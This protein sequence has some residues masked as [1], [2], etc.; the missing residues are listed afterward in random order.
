[1]PVQEMVEGRV[2]Q[3]HTTGTTHF[4]MPGA[5]TGAVATEGR[6]SGLVRASMTA[7][8]LL[9]RVITN[10]A[11]TDSTHTSRKALGAGA[12]SSTVTALTTGVF[13]DTVNTDSLTTGQEFNSQLVTGATGSVTTTQSGLTLS[14]TGANTNRILQSGD[15]AAG[16]M[17]LIAGSF[18]GLGG[19]DVLTTKAETEVYIT[20]RANTTMSNIRGFT[21]GGGT[22]A[23]TLKSRINLADGAQTITQASGTQGAFEDVTNTD[24]VVTGNEVAVTFLV[25]IEATRNFMSWQQIGTGAHCRMINLAGTTEA[26]SADLYENPSGILIGTTTESQVQM[27]ARST[28]VARDLFANVITHGTSSG[29]DVFIRVGGANSGVTFNV[30][31]ST[32]GLFEDN[33][34]TQNFVATNLYNYFLDHGGGGGSMTLV[35]LAMTHVPEVLGGGGGGSGGGPGQGNPPPGRGRGGQPPAPPPP[36]T[37][38]APRFRAPRFRG[39]GRH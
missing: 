3:A 20:F 6:T 5:A 14:N 12:M 39:W 2:S 27:T 13:Q 36:P 19:V 15:G 33:T 23:V 4:I 9:L 34:N 10:A 26:V 16:A 31:Q 8:N 18:A 21:V 35:S 25:D 30:A 7:A 32:T 28:F 17:G 11:T 38:Q 29:V 24:S 37:R 1:M 22:S